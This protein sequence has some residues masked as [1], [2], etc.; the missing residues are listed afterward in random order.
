MLQD[1][2]CKLLNAETFIAYIVEHKLSNRSKNAKEY[3]DPFYL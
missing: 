3:K 2:V 1:V